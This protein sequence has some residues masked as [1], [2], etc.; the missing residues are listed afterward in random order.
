MLSIKTIKTVKHLHACLNEQYKQ[1]N[2]VAEFIYEQNLC[3][4]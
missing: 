4:N 3:M 1:L 2:E